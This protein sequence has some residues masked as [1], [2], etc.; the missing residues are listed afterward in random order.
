[1]PHATANGVAA[2]SLALNARRAAQ[3]RVGQG[4]SRTR[5]D[6]LDPELLLCVFGALACAEDLCAVSAVQRGWRTLVRATPALWRAVA[7]RPAH[8]LA[9]RPARRALALD[10]VAEGHLH[11][12]DLR[13]LGDRHILTAKTESDED[14]GWHRD[15]DEDGTELDTDEEADDDTDYFIRHQALERN[16]ARLRAALAQIVATNPELRRLAVSASAV[17]GGEWATAAVCAPLGGYSLAPDRMRAFWPP[18]AAALSFDG[19]ASLAVKAM[20]KPQSLAALARTL[21]SNVALT[22]DVE[23][24]WLHDLDALLDLHAARH[25]LAL[26]ALTLRDNGVY[27]EELRAELVAALAPAGRLGAALR[28]VVTHECVSDA[29]QDWL[30]APVLQALADGGAPFL[31]TLEM[32]DAS[33]AGVRAVA[34]LLRCGTV[35]SLKR[36]TVLMTQADAGA[37]A[38]LAGALPA[39]LHTMV[40]GLQHAEGAPPVARDP[41][42]GPATPGAGAHVT[43]AALRALLFTAAARCP[44]LRSAQLTTGHGDE[45]FVAACRAAMVDFAAARRDVHASYR[46][47]SLFGGPVLTFICRQRRDAPYLWAR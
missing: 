5:I 36:L 31:H 40:L 29:Q 4:A 33:P 32:R 46:S 37:L 16:T 43:A 35:F 9:P 30:H 1:V 13:P 47:F 6:A 7:F 8:A 23:V 22:A 11:S 3:R 20:W 41:W 45:A 14:V 26:D 10:A 21:P 24:Y 18:D 38:A 27:T 15:E 44:N 42:R 19:D 34:A 25:G 28:H 2:S 17:C 39:T 12:L